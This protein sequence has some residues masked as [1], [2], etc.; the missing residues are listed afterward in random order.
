MGYYKILIAY[1][2]FDYHGWQVQPEHLTIA[3]ILQERFKAVFQKDIILVGASRTDA[4]VHALGQVAIFSTDFDC[5]PEQLKDAWNRKLPPSIL[6]RSLERADPQFH[7][8][9]NVNYKIYWYHV[10]LEQPLPFYARYGTWIKKPLNIEK[11]RIA[12]AIFIGTHDFRS[13]CTGYERENTVRTLYSIKLKYIVAYKVYR[14]EIKGNSF[15]RYM[16]RRIVGACLEI[17][18]SSERDIQEL[19]DALRARDPLQL[20][21]TAPAQGLMLRKIV[22]HQK[23]GK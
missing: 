3:G 1:D 17:A 8:Q 6:I 15:L 9:K 20:L 12:L 21:P 7:S 23:A 2:G 16:I 19:V 10:F 11:L 18:S 13:F 14:I 22:Y 4:G 5:S